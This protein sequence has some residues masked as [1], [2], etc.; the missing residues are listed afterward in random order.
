MSPK[1]IPVAITDHPK[2][3]T[4]V[5]IARPIKVPAILV[6]ALVGF[7]G[8]LST[9]VCSANLFAPFSMARP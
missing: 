4:K 5:P 8:D 1:V 7:G 2:H 9:K 6:K 3:S